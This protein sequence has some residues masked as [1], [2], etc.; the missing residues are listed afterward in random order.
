MELN[1]F[2]V[3]CLAVNP[4]DPRKIIVNEDDTVA[5]C[6]DCHRNYSLNTRKIISAH[7]SRDPKTGRLRYLLETEDKNKGRRLRKIEVQDG[8][9]LTP[10]STITLVWRGRQLVGISDHNRGLWFNIISRPSTL[11]GLDS[12]YKF[13]SV[14]LLVCVLMQI[15]RWLPQLQEQY[16]NYGTGLILATALLAIGIIVIPKLLE[17]GN[18]LA[19]TKQDSSQLPEF[20]SSLD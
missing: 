20:D 18:Q 13:L 11:P 17:M 8:L 3:C 14:I 15:L 2:C 6:P 10:G 16:V 7:S 4:D 1:V 12:F 19:A 9:N 5:S